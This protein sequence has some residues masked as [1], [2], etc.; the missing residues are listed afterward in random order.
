MKLKVRLEP[1][2]EHSTFQVVY[3][4]DSH[5]DRRI[6]I[7]LAGQPEYRR[8][9]YLAKQTEKYNQAPFVVVK[10]ARREAIANWR[11]LIAYLKNEGTRDCSVQRYKGLGEMNPEQLWETTS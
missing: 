7:E 10:E 4:D 8:L 1:E 3:H 5:G 6:G 9:R 11:E 2:E